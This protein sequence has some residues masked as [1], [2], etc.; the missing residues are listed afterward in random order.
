MSRVPERRPLRLGIIGC[1]A[2]ARLLYARTLP[3]LESVR[4]DYVFDLDRAAADS[5][6]KR[7]DARVADLEQIV[8]E[9]E[10]VIIA[11]PP[12][13]HAELIRRCLRPDRIVVCEKPFVPTV[14]EAIELADRSSGL[15]S[16]LFVGH[17]RRNYPAV[18]LAR[19]LI[20]TRPYG[21]LKRIAASEGGRF[22]WQTRTGYVSTDALGGVLFDTGSHLVD[23][24]LYAAGMEGRLSVA[25][26]DLRRD[27]PEPA[28][29]VQATMTLEDDASRVQMRLMLS[30]YEALAN[31][32][33]FEF[34]RGMLEIPV[35]P[36]N[37]ARLSGEGGSTL[38][39]RR[40]G[41]STQLDCL[42]QQWLAIFAPK[43]DE[44]Y[45]ASRFLAV[46]SGLEAL[47]AR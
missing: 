38:L 10:V 36:R 46:T 12:G 40:G 28:H 25:V 31:C 21:A 9:A 23:M 26:Q 24:A 2:V 41:D 3:R 44:R 29:E 18:A 22:D 15:R 35:T 7:L 37:A 11:T 39:A 16:P 45:Q 17:F 19:E 33:R 34:E 8:E 13:S 4:T 32:I 43:P 20:A 14:A 5:L 27:Q 47:A 1:G 42:T 30:R 6:A